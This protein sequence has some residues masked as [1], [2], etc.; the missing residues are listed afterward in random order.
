M[1]TACNPLEDA[2][3]SIFGFIARTAETTDTGVTWTTINYENQPHHSIQVFN[4]VGGIPFFLTDYF[5]RY[6]DRSA[7]ALGQHAIDWCARFSEKH[8]KRGVH[9]GQTGAA[10]AALHR[11]S[12]LGELVPDF[13]LANAH[14]ILSEPSGPVTDLLGGEASNGFFL[15]KLWTHTGDA[16]FLAGAERCAAWIETQVIRDERGAYCLNHQHHKEG[17]WARIFLGAA[18]GQSGIAHFLL[19]LTEITGRERWANLARELLATISRYARPVHGGVN[20]PGTICQEDITRCQWSHGA[21]GIGLTYLKAYRVLGDTAYLDTAVQAA[22][23]TY[24]YGDYRQ[25]YTQCTGLAG[26]GELLL[27]TYRATGDARWQTRALDFAH[28][29]LAYKETTPE[30]D[31]WPTDAKGLYSADLTTAPPASATSSSACAV[32]APSRCR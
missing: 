29:C 28:R 21:P 14:F 17:S 30:G 24:G 15:L 20:W 3:H 22:E 23:A 16:Q 10:L 2:I 8:H 31:A 11:A 25:N 27:E 12:V 7:L 6:G 5:R 19:C 4:G 26:S 18:H 32:M 13:S 9:M 1:T